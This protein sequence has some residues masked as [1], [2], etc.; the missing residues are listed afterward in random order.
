MSYVWINSTQSYYYYEHNTLKNLFPYSS[1]TNQ[2]FLIHALHSQLFTL[3]GIE[4]CTKYF[5]QMYWIVKLLLPNSTHLIEQLFEKVGSI[6]VTSRPAWTW[7]VLFW[8]SFAHNEN[9]THMVPTYDFVSAYS[10]SPLY[11]NKCKKCTNFW[12]LR[13]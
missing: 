2:S 11:L 4:S 12:I 7:T 6:A 5:C 13:S 10:T 3:Y 1:T 8:T 9:K